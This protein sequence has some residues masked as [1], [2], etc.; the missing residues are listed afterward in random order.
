MRPV[1]RK[2]DQLIFAP[3]S[4]PGSA[5]IRAGLAKS[6]TDIIEHLPHSAFL[7]RLA[8]ARAIVDN[9]SV[10]LIEAAALGVPCV[11]IGPR[12]GGRQKP[13]NVIDCDYGQK[14]VRAALDRAVKLDLSRLRHP[15]GDGQAGKRIADFLAT[16][17]LAQVSLRKR[18]WY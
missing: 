4:D 17:D 18:N 5:G 15:Y 6:S 16:I 1:P 8:Q 13:G 11:N 3:N 12:Q 9:S 10:W 2:Y 7:E 14:P